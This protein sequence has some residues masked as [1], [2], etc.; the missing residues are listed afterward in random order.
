MIRKTT[1]IEDYILKKIESGE[2]SVG[3]KLPSQNMLTR[4]FDCSRDTVVRALAKLQEGGY[5][6]QRRGKGTFVNSAEQ[7]RKVKEIIIISESIDKIKNNPFFLNMVFLE[8]GDIPTS[9][10]TV[11]NVLECSESIFRP[12]QAVIWSCPSPHLLI[13]MEHLRR[14]GFP[15]LLINRDYGQFDTIFTSPEESM[16]KG[17]S[18]L[19]I[20]GGRD[21]AFVSEESDITLPYIQERM[22]AFYETC[23]SLRANLLPDF[24][25]KLD[26]KNFFAGIEN[27]GRMLFDRPKVPGSIFVMTHYLVTPLL[28]CATRYGKKLGK[29]FCMLSFDEVP[30]LEGRKGFAVLKQPLPLFRHET[31]NWIRQLDTEPQKP[32]RRQLKCDLIVQG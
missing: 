15:Q 20:E 28:M 25:F 16:R 27:I 13:L 12:G 18:W 30:E 29:D 24:I 8:T 10:K 22:L 1:S 32:F 3:E 26:L 9:F 23:F 19:L 2:L 14:R 11:Q 17:I 21:M 7:S 31:E 6:V 5:I 4:R